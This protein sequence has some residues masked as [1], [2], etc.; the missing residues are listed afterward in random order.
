M[1]YYNVSPVALAV[2]S[3]V[4][5]ASKYFYTPADTARKGRPM[6]HHLRESRP[7]SRTC[8]LPPATCMQRVLD[9]YSRSGKDEHSE[10]AKAGVKNLE[11]LG[12]TGLVLDEYERAPAPS[13]LFPLPLT[14]PPQAKSRR[15]SSTRTTWTSASPVR[16]LPC[17]PHPR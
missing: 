9:M 7:P 8:Q 10:K 14:R 2:A 5:L 1:E 13:L 3:Q 15:R 4:R 6:V 12:H 17:A 16:P 11:R